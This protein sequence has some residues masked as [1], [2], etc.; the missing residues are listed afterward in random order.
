MNLLAIQHP[1]SIFGEAGARA[2][3]ALLLLLLHHRGNCHRPQILAHP[4]GGVLTSIA[5]VTF[6]EAGV[7]AAPRRRLKT[8]LPCP[9]MG[10]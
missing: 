10:S 8:S 2:A 7:S 3:P 4:S 9:R 1:F 6:L 5:G